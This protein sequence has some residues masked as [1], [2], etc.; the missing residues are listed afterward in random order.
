M[1]EEWEVGASRIDNPIF[2]AKVDQ[3]IW[4]GSVTITGFGLRVIGVDFIEPRRHHIPTAFVPISFVDI[5]LAA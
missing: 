2:K 4:F 5:K 1:I 3:Y